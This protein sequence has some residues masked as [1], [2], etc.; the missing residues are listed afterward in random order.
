MTKSITILFFMVLMSLVSFS[1]DKEAAK[2][3]VDEGIAYHD[4]GDYNGAIARY[5]KAL[6]LDK[7]N[8]L[9]LMEKAFSLLSLQKFDESIACCKKAIASGKGENSLATAYVTYGNALDGL[10]KTDQAIDIYNEGIKGF[11]NYYQLYFNKGVTLTSVKKLDEAILSFQKAISL[12][13][14]HASSHNGIARL[15]FVQNKRIPS[16]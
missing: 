3:L 4:K 8:V 12:K 1:Q 15:L 9:A 13:P 11:P 16:L 6:E 14:A 2:K 7:D 5:D 10:K